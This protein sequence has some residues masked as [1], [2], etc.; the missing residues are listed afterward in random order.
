MTHEERFRFL[1]SSTFPFSPPPPACWT[2]TSPVLSTVSSFSPYSSNRGDRES[3]YYALRPHLSDEF[4]PLLCGLQAVPKLSWPVAS[5]QFQ[6]CPG[7][8][9]PGSSKVVLIC[10]L[11][12]VPKLSWLCWRCLCLVPYNEERSNISGTCKIKRSNISCTY[13]IKRSNI[14]CTCRIKRSNISCTCRIK[15][16]N[17]SCICRIKRI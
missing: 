12:A 10:G 9:P 11:Q 16:S 5:R 4:A 2:S 17:V 13:R 7:L 1:S 8:W 6:S 15:R 3:P 14:T